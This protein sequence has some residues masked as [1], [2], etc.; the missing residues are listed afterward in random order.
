[1]TKLKY[2]GKMQWMERM[3]EDGRIWDILDPNGKLKAYHHST[4]TLEGL[5][6]LGV[7]PVESIKRPLNA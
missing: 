2:R 3:G 4:R 7:I 1:M 6:E 5:R